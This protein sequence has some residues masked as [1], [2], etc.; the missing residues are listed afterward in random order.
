MWRHRDNL[1]VISS[2]KDTVCILVFALLLTLGLPLSV[3]EDE[4][5]THRQSFER[6]VLRGLWVAKPLC[7]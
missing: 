7:G 5:V 6:W 4:I 3:H 2:K 1:G